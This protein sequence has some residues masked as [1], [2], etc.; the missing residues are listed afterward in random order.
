[1]CVARGSAVDTYVVEPADAPRSTRVPA[2]ECVQPKVPTHDA[3]FSAA[4]VLVCVYVC[5]CVCVCSFG[6]HGSFMGGLS[7]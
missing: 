2:C 7:V 3:Y 6:Y 1:M 5:E 4:R